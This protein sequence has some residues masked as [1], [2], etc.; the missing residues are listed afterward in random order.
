MV[1]QQCDAKIAA[2]KIKLE[3]A[4]SEV[5][6][7]VILRGRVSELEAKAVARSEEVDTLNKQ[8]AELLG[9]AFALEFGRGELNKH[10]IISG[11]DCERLKNK[12]AGEAKLR[13][14]FKSFQDAKARHFKEKF[15]PFID[16]V[17]VPI[18]SESIFFDRE[19]PLSEV[20][21]AVRLA[22][23]R[24]GLCPSSGSTAGMVVVSSLLQDLSLGVG[25]YQV[26][27]FTLD[28]DGVAPPP[29][30]T[31]SPPEDDLFDT[32]VLDKSADA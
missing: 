29:P 12:V 23:E 32:A 21:H 2:L 28:N 26:S 11:A 14:E 5:A 20:I 13:E 6:K 10:I 27:T 22:A 31:V 16:Q 25:D 8:N 24:R 7:V 3:K 9:K 30:V 18:Y 15:Q 1:V 4:K 19:I 17:T